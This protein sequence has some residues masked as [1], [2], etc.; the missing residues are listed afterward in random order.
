M[1]AVTFALPEESREFRKLLA[2]GK[3]RQGG[4]AANEIGT[5]HG[6]EV[7]VAHIGVGEVAAEQGIAALLEEIRP[8]LLICAGYGGALDPALRIGDLVLDLRQ[9]S[10][11]IQPPKHARIG[12]I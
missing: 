5:L 8:E 3:R 10:A 11:Q 4:K 9:S 2:E 6:A 1:Y 12:S 7:A